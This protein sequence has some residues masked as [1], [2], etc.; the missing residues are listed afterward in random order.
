[1][2]LLSLPN[3]NLPNWRDRF[4]P[5]VWTVLSTA[6]KIAETHHWHLYI[7]GGI[8]RD[9][10]L[11]LEA[12][13]ASNLTAKPI[14]DIDV[15][16]DS[17]TEASL[18][19]SAGIELAKSIQSLYPNTRLEIHETFQT[20]DLIWKNDP[21]FQSLSID[22][23]TART[24]TYAYPAA[25]PEVTTSSIFRDLYRRD[26]TINALA[27]RLTQPNPGE[28]LDFFDG[29]DDL[30][31]RQ[32]RVLHDRSF[33][34]DPT[35][36]Y[37]GARFAVRFGFEWEAQTKADLIAAIASGIYQKTRIEQVK[38]PAL[39][40]R[41]KAE[42][43]YTFESDRWQEFIKKLADVDAFSCLHP[44]LKLTDRVMWQLRVV[45]RIWRNWIADRTLDRWLMLL[46]I[47]LVSLPSEIA[48]AVAID[49]QLPS[50]SQTRL[51]THELHCKQLI[52]TLSCCQL[53]SEKVRAIA[54][55]D[56]PSLILMGAN[57][58]RKIRQD[59]WQYFTQWQLIKPPLD[60]RNLKTMGYAPG[61]QFRQILADLLTATLDGKISNRQEAE[62]FVL[63][64][65]SR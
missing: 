34:D 54:P 6:A 25:N 10:L 5:A 11:E 44:M 1:M 52:Q 39:Q 8:V 31:K 28:L 37:R 4:T 47:L 38:V 18:T 59:I 55:Y 51:A 22:F 49:L 17:A 19:P 23:A 50:E 36:M 14:P 29:I 20:A 40:T 26:F 63:E 58:P 21:K 2:S 41:L 53:V 27:V 45:D 12:E 64:N 32:L 65:Y 3:L 24:E 15:V 33:I 13:S 30:H 56:L 46:E 7:V 62:L 35:R 43:K 60:G 57:S 61:P 9:G 42:L 48:K 16:V